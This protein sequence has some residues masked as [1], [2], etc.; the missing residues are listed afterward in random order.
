MEAVIK[1]IAQTRESIND[2]KS[3]WIFYHT[4][5]TQFLT[6]QQ[7]LSRR[8]FWYSLSNCLGFRK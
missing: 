2:R 8:G 5:H 6:F 7:T 1:D 3:C 4:E